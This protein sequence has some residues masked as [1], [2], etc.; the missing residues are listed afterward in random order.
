MKQWRVRAS[1]QSIFVMWS[2]EW[3]RWVNVCTGIHP[4]PQSNEFCGKGIYPGQASVFISLLPDSSGVSGTLYSS[5]LCIFHI[6]WLFMFYVR[7]LGG[8]QLCGCC[9]I[10]CKFEGENSFQWEEVEQNA[11]HGRNSTCKQT[12]RGLPQL[13]HYHNTQ[14]QHLARRCRCSNFKSDW[15][16]LQVLSFHSLWPPWP[17]FSLLTFGIKS[18]VGGLFYSQLLQT[19]PRSSGITF[20]HGNWFPL[21]VHLNLLKCAQTETQENQ[22]TVWFYNWPDLL[23]DAEI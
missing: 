16:D 3:A 6:G 8:E 17:P 20:N 22:Y 14:K 13:L 21:Q 23:C 5:T 7:L 12:D 2:T 10:L 4:S 19:V 15:L 11:K 1:E 18:V 9:C